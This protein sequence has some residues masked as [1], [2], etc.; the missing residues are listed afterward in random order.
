[1]C[2]TKPICPICKQDTEGKITTYYAPLEDFICQ[3]CL[4][5]NEENSDK[6][7]PTRD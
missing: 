2:L 3:A 5:R 7:G 6:D 1:M 4:I